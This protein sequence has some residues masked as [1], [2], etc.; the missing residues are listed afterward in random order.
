VVTSDKKMIMMASR[1]ARQPADARV[2]ARMVGLR[3]VAA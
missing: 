1:P 2:A 3:A